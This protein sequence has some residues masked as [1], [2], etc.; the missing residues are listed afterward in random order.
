MPT[1]ASHS[2]LAWYEAGAAD[3]AAARQ[4]APNAQLAGFLARLP[5][6]AR[7]LE[8][9]CGAGDDALAM[10]A[11]GFDVTPSD[12]AAAMAQIAEA[13]LGRPVQV[14]DF[15]ELDE[16]RAYDAIWANACLLHVPRAELGRVLARIHRA[17]RPG[18]LHYSS[19]KSGSSE[20]QDRFGRFYNYPTLPE[21]REIVATAADWQLLD[22]T[23][24]TG[25]QHG[26][27]EIRWIG[28][29][30]RRPA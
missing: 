30:L 11:A 29:T 25:G 5:S 26:G 15:A 16:D 20:G 28:L 12:G 21:L 19:Y 27:G 10:L 17:L 18:G 24:W 2:V 1:V 4:A 14:L 7:V 22:A 8:L 6:G 9:G 3:W 13:R 23:E